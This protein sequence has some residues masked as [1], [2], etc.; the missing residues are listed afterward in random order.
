MLFSL[1]LIYSTARVTVDLRNLK[2]STLVDRIDDAIEAALMPTKDGFYA[3]DSNMSDSL[4][5]LSAIATCNNKVVDLSAYLLKSHRV[6][7]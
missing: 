7:A 6:C 5:E 3:A 2:A 1:C 4:V